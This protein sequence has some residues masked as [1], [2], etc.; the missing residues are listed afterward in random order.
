MEPNDKDAPDEQ[1]PAVDATQA[2]P[3]D[4]VEPEERATAAAA[5]E[6]P[7]AEP[8]E[9][10]NGQEAAEVAAPAE[11]VDPLEQARQ[12]VERFRGQMLR[13][14]ADFDNFRKRAR[15]EVDDA[16]RR[17]REEF[18]RE[19]LPVFD[20]L[21]RAAAHAE[22]VS[23]ARAVADGVKMVLKQFHD[24]LGKLGVTRIKAIGAP[25]DPN[26]HEAIQQLA[27]AE[28]PPGTVVAEVLAGYEW[29]ARL[30][31]ASM[32]VVSKAPPEPPPEPPAADVTEPDPEPSKDPSSE[33]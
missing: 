29:E 27:T 25:F 9:E 33:Q 15:R 13:I 7:A 11:R 3:A 2:V 28:Q 17:S 14:A 16:A 21:E 31:R 1:A 10:P 8:A 12:E 32:V 6:P 26:I 30:V 5:A 22:Q 19:L 24:T 20:N 18:L 23:D 4:Q